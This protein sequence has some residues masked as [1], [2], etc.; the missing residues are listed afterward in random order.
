M[1]E[2]SKKAFIITLVIFQIA[3]FFIFGFW[4]KY[5]ESLDETQDHEHDHRTEYY[6][7]YYS[8][9]AVMVLVGF[10]FLMTFLKKYGISALGYT[11]LLACFCV[12]LTII[13][14][15]FWIQ[16]DKY[17]KLKEYSLTVEA[18]IEGMFG[19][20]T[21]MISFGAVLGK[22]TPTQ[23]IL[24]AFFELIFYSF[25]IFVS[26]YKIQAVDIGGSLII[27]TFG[28]YFGMGL[29]SVLTSK[30]ETLNHPKDSSTRISDVF[31]LI[32]TIFL[33]LFWPSFNGA[34]GVP[35]SRFRVI[36]NT[37]YSLCGSC[38]ITFITS[39]LLHK[40]G[41][42]VGTSANLYLTPGGAMG[43]GLLAGLLST[44]GFNYITPFLTDKSNL[45]DTCG[46]H[47]LH[48]IPGLIGGFSSVIVVGAAKYNHD[49]YNG[50]FEDIFPK[51][52]RQYLHQIGAIY[53]TLAISLIGGAL[54]GFVLKLFTRNSNNPF[55]DKEF[56]VEEE[57]YG[58]FDHPPVSD[59][60]FPHEIDSSDIEGSDSIKK[61]MNSSSDDSIK[62]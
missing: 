12:Q 61:E 50:A 55:D 45:Q 24:V 30:K 21:V 8:D 48:G 15:A 51:G 60:Y 56:W 49:W 2:S 38:V 34:L 43:I 32:G 22:T 28:A 4:F 19:A 31:S 25:N 58:E 3:I 29:T 9:V 7:T 57:E 35:G 13:F 59:V 53:T 16:I 46:V 10:G 11:F 37:V 36:I 23:L 39:A 6:Y 42:A 27:H 17:E 41:V 44:I 5:D 52:D 54:T 18:L 20:A 62:I 40:G 14:N 1:F 47:N 26:I 33:W